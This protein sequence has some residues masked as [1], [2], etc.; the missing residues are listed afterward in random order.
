MMDALHE[1]GRILAA[2][3]R[4]GNRWLTM[5]IWMAISWPAMVI[6]FAVAIPPSPLRMTVVALVSILPL[7]ALFAIAMRAPLLWVAAA[8]IP[9]GRRAILWLI[10]FLGVELLIGTYLTL[11][12]V[13]SNRNLVLPLLLIG[14][15]FALL[16]IAGWAS[17]AR[18][19]LV[20]IAIGITLFFLFGGPT[21]PL[22]L[23]FSSAS[24]AYP[25][26]NPDPLAVAASLYQADEAGTNNHEHQDLDHF[27]LVLTGDGEFGK[28]GHVRPPGSWVD[29]KVYWVSH[30]P[31]RHVGFLYSG[32][33]Y[34]FG[35]FGA[36]L[37]P[38]DDPRFNNTVREWTVQGNGTLRYERIR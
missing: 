33:S 15:A 2:L 11:V 10:G 9:T 23:P 6:L 35:P 21:P 7:F 25:G 32:R 28:E 37:P 27:D 26:Y 8:A 18:T 30:E 36:N 1:L 5:A 17:W 12:P 38:I 24:P 34:S 22:P 20:I 13:S 14:V 16:K 3:Y 19:I 31:D 29:W 4:I